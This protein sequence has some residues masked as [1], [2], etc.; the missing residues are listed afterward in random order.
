MPRRYK[1]V[2]SNEI[3]PP[4]VF[5][6][7]DA[8]IQNK[9]RRNKKQQNNRARGGEY[10]SLNLTGNVDLGATN[11]RQQNRLARRRNG[12][13]RTTTTTT[14]T[15]QHPNTIAEI[16]HPNHHRHNHYD[17]R[18]QK[19]HRKPEATSAPNLVAHRPETSTARA[20]FVW[21]TSTT[22]APTPITTRSSSTTQMTS[23]ESEKVMKIWGFTM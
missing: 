12:T 17:N 2:I 10:K 13:R 23:K 16:Y 1:G 8:S 22:A 14:T 9:L 3:N 15:T 11:L 21:S 18:E 7:R 6:T 5:S 20:L 19:N 4:E